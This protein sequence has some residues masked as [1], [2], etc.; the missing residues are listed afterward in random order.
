MAEF[1]NHHWLL[2]EL[3]ED[4]QLS[5]DCIAVEIRAPKRPLQNLY[6]GSTQTLQSELWHK[7]LAFY[8]YLQIQQY[9]IEHIDQSGKICFRK[10]MEGDLQCL[11]ANS[12]LQNKILFSRFCKQD[13]LF[14]KS[15]GPA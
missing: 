14:L 5:F 1:I 4:Y 12:I 8:C 11:S 7:L 10:G 13:Q 6:N 9:Y 3:I 2:K 15:I